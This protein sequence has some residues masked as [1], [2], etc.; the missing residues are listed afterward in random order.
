MKPLVVVTGASSG[1]GAAIARV[2]SAIGYSLALL[3]RRIEPMQKL[4]LPQTHCL[5]VDVTDA[6]AFRQA[7]NHIENQLGPIDCLINNAGFVKAGDFTEVSHADN[8]N[9]VKVNLL[10]VMNGIEA[11]LPGMRKRGVGTIINISS[12]ADRKA[13]PQL[14]T[15]AATKAAVRSLS[16]SLRVANAKYGIRIC[17]LAPAKTLTPMLVSANL[18]DG[19]V[20]KAEDVANAVLYMY[21][22]PPTVCIRDLV[23][24]PTC[25]EP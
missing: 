4:N 19:E 8:E 6:Q 16:E 22:L 10:G 25:Y 3:A 24:A 23:I 11:V 17:N 15:Y 2:F 20:I 9:T 21:Q 1:I 18:K 13:R 5:A 14:P 7:I 12:V